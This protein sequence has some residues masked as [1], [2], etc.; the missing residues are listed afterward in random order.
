MPDS[1]AQI[2]A[3]LQKDIL[4]LQGF[5]PMAAGTAPE[6]GWGPI[7]EAFPN[8]RFPLA[9]IHEFICRESTDEAA[10]SGFMA[11]ILSALLRNKGNLVWI[12]ASRTLFPPALKAFGIEPDRVIFVDLQK[13]KDVVWAMEESLRCGAL[14]AV[15]GELREI[16][17]TASRRLQLVVEQSGVTGFIL[18]R[19][20]ANLNITACVSRWKINPLPGLTEDG[21]PGIGFPCW[22]V[23]LVKVRNGRPGSWQMAWVDGEFRYISPLAAL[24]PD[25]QKKTG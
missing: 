3:R 10:S 17:F 20:P 21:L 7:D 23:A 9:A 4:A 6:I 14:A 1:K 16:S 13:E 22:Q 2:M 18:R 11:G 12:S 8:G 19:H 15:V 25:Q 5:G 24:I